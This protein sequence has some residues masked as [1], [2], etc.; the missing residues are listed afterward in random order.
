[1]RRVRIELAEVA[2]IPNLMEA[3][4]RAARGKHERPVVRAFL[5]RLEAHLAVL[6]EDIVAGRSRAANTAASA[7]ATPSR[8]SSM[9]PASPT[10]SCI[11]PSC[12]RPVRC[13]SGP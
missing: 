1:M 8:A 5:D 13:W 7:S 12:F 10:G 6:A 11:T 4:A 3:T 2:A 9:P